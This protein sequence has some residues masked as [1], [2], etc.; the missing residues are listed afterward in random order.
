MV[1]RSRNCPTRL[2]TFRPHPRFLLPRFLLGPDDASVD[3]APAGR[4]KSERGGPFEVAQWA[5][6]EPTGRFG[7]CLCVDGMKSAFFYL[8]EAHQHAQARRCT[9]T[10]RR[11]AFLRFSFGKAEYCRLTKLARNDYDSI[12]SSVVTAHHPFRGGVE[13]DHEA[14]SPPLSPPWTQLLLRLCF[15]WGLPPSADGAEGG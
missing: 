14:V 12:S 11:H 6:L 4:R 2:V 1:P 3:T 9:S 8:K 7:S 13:I 5:G 10:A 15:Q